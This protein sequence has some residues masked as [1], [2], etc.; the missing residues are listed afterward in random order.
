MGIANQKNSHTALVKGWFDFK[1][2]YNKSIESHI[3]DSAS[4]NIDKVSL[5]NAETTIKFLQFDR[6]TNQRVVAVNAYD[7]Q[8]N[9]LGQM[10]KFDY[11]VDNTLSQFT[12]LEG[13]NML[14]AWTPTYNNGVLA[15][16]EGV[17]QSETV[18]SLRYDLNYQVYYDYDSR[19]RIIDILYSK[20]RSKINGNG[21]PKSLRIETAERMLTVSFVYKADS[22]DHWS[23][24]TLSGFATNTKVQGLDLPEKTTK[25]L[26]TVRFEQ[27][28]F[29]A[30]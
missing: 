29:T 25:D 8:G 21:R 2:D 15:S 23:T 11:A 20:T 10:F 13:N 4:G 5:I 22:H 30:Q 12:T 27:A 16:L 3:D 28:L 19:G 24:A 6:D 14:T 18:G 9:P 17:R 1:P 26:G 7:S